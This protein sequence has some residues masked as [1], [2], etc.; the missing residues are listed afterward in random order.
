MRSEGSTPRRSI[1]RIAAAAAIA[2]VWGGVAAPVAAATPGSVLWASRFNGPESLMDGARAAALSPNGTIL[3]VTGSLNTATGPD[4]GTVAYDAFTGGVRWTRRYDGPTSFSDM[5]EAIAVSSDGSTVVVTGTSSS[6]ST[7][8][9]YATVAYDAASG[10]TLWTRRYDGPARSYDEPVGVRIT[11]DGATAVVTGYT[12]GADSRDYL[13]V[14]YATATGSRSWVRRYDPKGRDDVARALEVSPDGSTVFV[15]G[16]SSRRRTN[17]DFATVAYRTDTGE[18]R[19]VSR[20]TE[21]NSGDE[22]RSI[23]VAPDGSTVFVTGSSY[24]ST[25][26]GADYLTVAYDAS[27]GGQRWSARY[28]GP[29]H[30]NDQANA[31]AVA[32]DGASVVVT[33]HAYSR[34]TGDDYATVA[35]DAA[36]GGEHWTRRYVGAGS[37]SSDDAQD[38]VVS[39][40]GATVVV[41]GFSYGSTTSNDYATVAYDASAGRRLWSSRYDGPGDGDDV[42]WDLEAGRSAVFVTGSGVGTIGGYDWATV[43]YALD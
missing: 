12:S 39:G 4:F 22:P 32:P 26:E 15:T 35:Y 10:R 21:L 36:T 14:A 30:A 43:A 24:A 41:T 13:T 8:F 20:F 28:Q 3:F 23:G 29:G 27:T 34:T 6:A 25:D 5:A 2:V 40:D 1:V 18:R 16:Y 7:A 37:T 33:G 9:D 38:V 17:S 11:P 19:W 42:A 31:I